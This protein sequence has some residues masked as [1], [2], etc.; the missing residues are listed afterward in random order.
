MEGGKEALED[1][2][3]EMIALYGRDA[4][5]MLRDRAVVADQ[6]GDNLQARAWREIAAMA[7]RARPKPV[8]ASY[9]PVARRPIRGSTGRR[10]ARHAGVFR[11][12]SGTLRQRIS[13]EPLKIGVVQVF[14]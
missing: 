6:Y 5:K 7:A 8:I 13:L 3:R 10:K 2:A 14:E 9:R 4:P 12:G 1:V 11:M